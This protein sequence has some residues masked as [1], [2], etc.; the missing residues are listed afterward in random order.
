MKPS[1]G[2]VS[3]GHEVT[4]NAAKEILLVGGNAFDA[5]LAALFASC[6][7]EPVLASLG[8]GGF[9]MAQTANE[10][11]SL[12]DF[13]VQT[14]HDRPATENLDFYPIVADFGT[15]QQEFHIGMGSIA[16]PGA[17]KGLFSIHK[18]LCRLP[19]KEIIQPAR[20]AALKGIRVN[21]FQHHIADLVSPIIKSS[22]EALRLH[23]TDQNP[24]SIAP[25][26]EIIT[27]PEM[28]D[29]FEI[30][31]HEGEALF[32]QGEMGRLLIDACRD[33][34]GCL[35]TTDLETYAVERREPL[36]LN[37]RHTR[38]FTNPP[39]SVG[40]ILIAFALSLLETETIS[41]YQ[42]N[43]LNHLQRIAH[44][45]RL[46]Q[47][48]RNQ[49]SIGSNPD[50]NGDLEILSH[51]FLSRY[52]EI[53]SNHKTFSRGTTQIS[54]A[55]STGNMAS[56]TLSN[57]EGSGYVLPGCGIM[58]NNMLGE[59]D[60]NPHGFHQWP[61]N[62]RIASMMS[63]SLVIADNGDVIAT[64]SGGSNRIRSAIMQVLINL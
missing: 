7:A 47:E 57:G 17:I 62:R 16:T 22:P 45:M 18:D 9:L 58:L 39:P 46:T 28:A 23:A 2:V 61:F 32:Y 13:F 48:L 12:Y 27:H 55:D 56:M 40:G 53:M 43:S 8:G 15:V 44:A 24:D 4:A 63:P 49:R 1:I 52:R 19:L 25:T 37:Y 3:A 26:N 21:S 6:I 50:L 29:A 64:G 60:I 20:E 33:R 36:T 35:T 54:I 38:L 34:G 5:A 59:E 10:K 51:E 30:L 14:P 11:P 31:A 41:R 42:P